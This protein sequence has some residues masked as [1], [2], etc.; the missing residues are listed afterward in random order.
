MSEFCRGFPTYFLT[1]GSEQGVGSL[2]RR[3]IQQAGRILGTA[4]RYQESLMSL[5]HDERRFF[6]RTMREEDI[7]D[8]TMD[9]MIKRGQILV[10]EEV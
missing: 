3:T 8:R 10:H 6:A 7:N 2:L 9:E 4:H 5:D 1:I